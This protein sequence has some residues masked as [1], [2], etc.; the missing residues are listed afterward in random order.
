MEKDLHQY[1]TNLITHDFGLEISEDP[2]TEEQLFALLA[3]AVA[4]MIEHRIDFL[5]SLLYRLDVNE[6][7]INRALSPAA[8]EPANI[9]LARLIMDRQKQRIHTK[10]T[11][12]PAP[13]DDL[14]G[15]EF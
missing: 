7:K 2:I 12:K 6:A 4:T 9:G 10:K 3:D 5:L 14:E 15:L 8:P 1:T 11:Y 13:I